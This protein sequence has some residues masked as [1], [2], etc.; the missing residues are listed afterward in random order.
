MLSPTRHNPGRDLDAG[1]ESAM[2]QAR[3]DVGRLLAQAKPDDMII[4]LGLGSGCH[5]KAILEHGA[6][7]RLTVFDP[8]QGRR[9]IAPQLADELA[10]LVICR[11]FNQLT[12]ELAAQTVYGPGGRVAVFPTPGHEQTMPGQLQAVRKLVGEVMGRA[13]VDSRTRLQKNDLWASYVAENT[14]AVMA[15]PEVSAWRGILAGVPALIIGAGPS[16]TESLPQISTC[17]DRMLLMGAASILGPLDK[18]RLT[19]HCVTALEAKDE[20]RQFV[21]QERKKVLLA[22][23][24]NS[25][26]NHFRLWPGLTGHFHLLPWVAQAFGG[27]AL[28]NGGH[29]TSAAFTLALL[30]GCDPIILVG[31]DLAYTGGMVHAAGRVGGEDD[32][33]RQQVAVPAIGGGTVMTSSVFHS[34]LSWYQE[35]MGYLARSGNGTRVINCTT[36]G[37]LIPGMVH[38]PLE[39]AINQCPDVTIS[40]DDVNTIYRRS[41]KP[42]RKAVIKG[43]A[44]ASEQ[45][46]RAIKA[47][48]TAAVRSARPGSAVAYAA[49]GLAHTDLADLLPGKLEHLLEFIKKAEGALN[50]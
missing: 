40:H 25:H 21:G 5:V 44:A 7:V 27:T 1:L 20:S 26:P 16:L 47:G 34:Y 38:M 13:R 23:A 30:W 50:D 31:Q 41:P 24:S 10:T 28:P 35:S 33:V 4:V 22:A 18:A 6:G 43:L 2:R 39:Q 12:E 8:N 37:A 14:G 42:R 36:K 45:V 11:D 29:A 9:S 32:G 46:A 19:P 49:E 3:N 48:P 17:Q 15:G